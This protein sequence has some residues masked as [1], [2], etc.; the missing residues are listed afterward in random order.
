MLFKQQRDGESELCI[1]LIML[2]VPTR[3]RP[4]PKAFTLIELLV[5]IAIIAILA[6]LL[7]PSFQTARQNSYRTT[8]TGNLKQVAS[9]ILA[10]AGDNEM[11]L[12]GPLTVG[13][14][15]KYSQEL[16]ETLGFRLWKYIGE[17]EPT[18]TIQQAKMLSNPAYERGR[19]SPNAPAYV[20]NQIV[21]DDTGALRKPW[22]VLGGD[23][24]VRTPTVA[25]WSDNTQLWALQDVDQLNVEKLVGSKPSWFGE[26]PVKPVHGA[27]RLVLFFDWHIEPVKVPDQTGS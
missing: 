18:G 4:L 26:L 20:L 14:G 2:I 19:Q 12:P 8:A 25:S 7:F 24:P 1:L 22:G 27:V 10:Y 5:V 3:S 11:S 16:S 13:Q 6:G 15:P 23:S 17:A 21:P 9:G